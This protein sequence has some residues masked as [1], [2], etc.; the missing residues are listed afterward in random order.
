MVGLG[1]VAENSDNAININA[2]ETISMDD[3]QQFMQ[4]SHLLHDF[5]NALKAILPI[6]LLLKLAADLS[7]DPVL[8]F[9]ALELIWREGLT[10]AVQ[11]LRILHED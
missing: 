5:Q 6:S 11:P 1:L 4:V 9:V 8:L 7:H 10:I 3:K 2:Q